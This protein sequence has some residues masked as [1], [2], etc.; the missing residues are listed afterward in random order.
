MNLPSRSERDRINGFINGSLSGLGITLVIWGLASLGS[1]PS[2]ATG[3]I[4]LALLGVLALVGGVF[5]EAYTWG[6]FSTHRTIHGKLPREHPHPS[7]SR[8][9]VLLQTRTQIPAKKPISIDHLTPA[10]T[11]EYPV[12]IQTKKTVVYQQEKH[13]Q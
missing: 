6:R 3:S 2:I 9:V 12:G 11:K 8:N 13:E 1:S 4:N 5:R 10:Q 7:T